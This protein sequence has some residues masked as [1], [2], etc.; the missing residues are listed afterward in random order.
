MF[1]RVTEL[2]ARL[3]DRR[4]DAMLFAFCRAHKALVRAGCAVR[5]LRECR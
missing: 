5:L 2:D 1:R 3:P 4:V